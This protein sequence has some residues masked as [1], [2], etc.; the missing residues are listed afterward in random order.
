MI[1]DFLLDPLNP[2]IVQPMSGELPAHVLIV[3]VPK[4]DFLDQRLLGVARL[5][6]LDPVL[7]EPREGL[8]VG[9]FC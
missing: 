5:D 9:G 6:F 1:T 3:Y 7:D 2:R 4:N 8:R